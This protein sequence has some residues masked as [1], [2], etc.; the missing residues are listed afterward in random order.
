VA[1]VALA[2]LVLAAA[3]TWA[4]NGNIG[5]FF[6]EGAALC[7]A[8]V[9]CGPPVTLYVYGLLQ[10]ASYTGITGAEYKVQVGA[11][12]SADA[13]WLFNEVFDP[14]ATVIGTGAFNPVDPSARGVNVSWATCQV[15][16]GTK[17]LIETVSILN[18]SCSTAELEL[19]V[20]KHDAASNQFFQCPLFVL[21]DAPVFTKVCLGSNQTLCRNPEPP[22]PTNATCSTSGRAFINPTQD[23]SCQVAVEKQTWS[24][25]KSLYGN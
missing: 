22:F 21:C 20:V 3:P 1:T 11:N 18:T 23:R 25:V 4:V 19:K 24:G 16:D 6:D 9:P 7:K 12:N 14:A 17:V 2:T 5:L 8:P 10:G 15:G 13:G